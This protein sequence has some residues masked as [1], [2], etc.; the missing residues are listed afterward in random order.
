MRRVLIFALIGPPLGFATA[1][2]G[3]LQIL[4]WALG[5]PST[6]DY[7]HVVL[8]PFAYVVG[9]VPA[10]VVAIFDSSLAARHIGYR[11]LWTTLFAYAAGFIPLGAFLMGFIHSPY[12]LFFGLV[13]AVP[14]AVCSWLAM[15]AQARGTVS[16]EC[17]GAH[18]M[19]HRAFIRNN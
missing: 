10:L 7:H 18:P 6:F 5:S 12:I 19:E 16:T 1:Y 9:I 15:D 14:G 13:G 3:L 17:S 8:L 11:V 4:N 2:W